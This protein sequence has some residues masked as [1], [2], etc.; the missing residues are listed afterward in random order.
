MTSG[1]DSVELAEGRETEMPSSSKG[2]G[3]EEDADVDADELGLSLL[4]AVF[5][6]TSSIGLLACVAGSGTL[7]AAPRRFLLIAG[8]R[9]RVAAALIIEMREWN[10]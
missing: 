9:V 2:C 6:D 4:E 1:L 3:W 7:E 8:T 5:G 10:D